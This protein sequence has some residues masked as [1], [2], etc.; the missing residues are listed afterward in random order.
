[1]QDNDWT[2]QVIAACDLTP[3]STVDGELV[4]G[5][6]NHVYRFTGDRISTPVLDTRCANGQGRD[7]TVSVSN[8]PTGDLAVLDATYDYSVVKQRG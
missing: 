2:V 5:A 7:L 3:G 8:L 6:G 4:D 1:V